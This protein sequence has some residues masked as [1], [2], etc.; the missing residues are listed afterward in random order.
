MIVQIIFNIDPWTINRK[1]YIIDLF[2][3]KFNVLLLRVASNIK[4]GAHLYLRY[5][6][7]AHCRGIFIGK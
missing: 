6:C 2:I 4:H 1:T 5:R 7:Y 3:I